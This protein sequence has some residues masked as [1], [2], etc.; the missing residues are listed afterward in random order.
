MEN[1]NLLTNYSAFEVSKIF[2][3]PLDPRVLFSD[4]VTAVCQTEFAEPNDYYYSY[5]SLLE[6]DKVYVI[7]STGELTQENVSPDSPNALN[8]TDIVSPE[9]YVKINELASAKEA[10]I[11]R[12]LKTINRAMNF[13]E[14]YV[15]VGLLKAAVVGLG[16]NSN[17][18]ASGET[19]FDYSHLVTMI[20]QVKDYG[21]TFVL[22]VGSTIDKQIDLWNWTDN[23]YQSLSSALA[24]LNVKIIRVKETVSIDGS[25]TQVLGA[26]EVLLVANNTTMGKPVLFVRKRLNEIDLL[27]AVIK[28]PGEERPQRII[29]ATPNPQ[30]V[31]GSNKRYMAVGIYGYEEIACAVVNPYAVSYFTL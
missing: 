1:V 3:E 7:T 26:S 29:F 28:Q 4:L 19:H 24:D 20:H 10:T 30:P 14:N 22:L 25:S 6:T 11:A 16:T 8:F 13:Y 17:T 23:K 21:D 2:G 9:Y 27:G 31:I 15:V 18:L 12:K 5:D